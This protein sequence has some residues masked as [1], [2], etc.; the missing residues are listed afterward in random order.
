[1]KNE[2]IAK[3]FKFDLE[4]GRFKNIP[5]E[6]TCAFIVGNPPTRKFF[7]AILEIL[8]FK[9]DHYCSLY[10]FDDYDGVSVSK[11]DMEY[12]FFEQDDE[13]EEFSDF[14]NELPEYFKEGMT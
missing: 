13:S 6:D 7:I 11:E 1:M 3:R 4:M 8:G 12:W 10:S 5:D 14:D 9:K 2:E